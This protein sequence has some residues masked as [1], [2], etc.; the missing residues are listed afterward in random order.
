[1]RDGYEAV[2]DDDIIQL[3]CFMFS[4]EQYA[5][6]VFN[7]RAVISIPRIAPVPQMPGFTLGVINIRGNIIPVFDLRKK[8][9]L[10]EKAVTSQSKLLIVEVNGSQMSFLI[11]AILDNIKITRSSI[12]PSPQVKM[13]IKRECISGLGHVNDRMI[14]ILDID[15]LNESINEDILKLSRQGGERRIV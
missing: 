1:M 2:V 4:S 7:V 15:R 5:V 13:K 10:E 3:V 12:D 11:D 6:N 8:F 14:I 9:G